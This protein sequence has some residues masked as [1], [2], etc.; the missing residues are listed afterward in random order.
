MVLY[1]LLILVVVWLVPT[2]SQEVDGA[3]KQVGVD[4]GEM[5][6]QVVEHHLT[7]CHLVLITT[8]PRSFVFSRIL[9]HLKKGVVAG[10]VVEAGWVLSQDKLV[11]DRLFQG[12]WGDTRTSC[13]G[14]IVDLTDANRTDTGLRLMTMSG[15]HFRSQTTVLIVG[16]SADMK[17]VFLHGSLRNTL[18]ALYLA[19]HDPPQ[20]STSRLRKVITQETA[21]KRV[22]V[23]RR[24]LF[25][26]N[27]EQKI[28]F[29]SQWNLN[30]PVETIAHLF[31]EQLQDMMGHSLSIVTVPYFPYIDFQSASDNLNDPVKTKDSLDVRIINT[32]AA[33]LNFTYNVYAEP[34]RSFGEN[35]VGNF[36]GM[37][38][39][40]QREERD[41]STIVAPTPA[42]LRVVDYMSGYPS[43]PLTLTSLKPATLPPS[44]ALLRPLTGELWLALLV[45]VL[46]W[47]VALWLLQRAWPRQ[48]GGRGFTLSDTLL[49]S[50][51][52]LLAQTPS[53]PS[54]S[55]SGRLLVGTWL[56]FCLIITT[57]YSSSLIAHLTVQGTTRPMDTFEDLLQQ[58]NWKWGVDPWLYKGATLEYFSKH[59][60]PVVK[61]IYNG[62][63]MLEAKE[64]LKK[65]KTGGYSLI[66][67]RNYIQ[68]VVASWYTDTNGNT[69]F[70]ISNKGISVI[71]AFGWAIRKVVYYF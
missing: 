68:V 35:I 57:V 51:G 12:L 5:V 71:A 16:G 30:S 6:G 2:A 54:V 29:I 34:T 32:F 49:Y 27:G 26:N 50:W 25:C 69:P 66:D 36:S 44:L 28:Q 13:R 53:N 40:L 20:Q 59:P 31:Q 37:I 9:R 24:C 11:Q 3:V 14:L 62:M 21:R 60:S 58:H 64:A 7:S 70:Y 4:V 19:V 15:L 48:E 61:Q 18:H 22:W 8:T 52:S 10:V 67:H 33:L 23:Y 1:K 38:G 17:A 43:D 55:K 42:R 63:E 47:G 65:V 56:V 45:S 41:L 46:A 39:E